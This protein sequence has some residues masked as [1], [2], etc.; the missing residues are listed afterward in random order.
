ML[1]E[2]QIVPIEIKI[3]KGVVEF[4]VDEHPRETNMEALS[5]LKPVFKENGTVTAGN[6]SGRN[7]GAGVV[8]L[9]KGIA[10]WGCQLMS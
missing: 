6:S 5:K 10:T 2:E 7:D 4:K 3:K 9:M 1:F 8:L